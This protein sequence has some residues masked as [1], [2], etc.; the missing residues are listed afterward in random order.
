[1]LKSDA[2]F[3]EYLKFILWEC[4]SFIPIHIKISVEG[5]LILSL[6]MLL[7]SGFGNLVLGVYELCT[8]GVSVTC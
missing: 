8:W 5:S 7:N 4:L 6:S 1:M 3:V 2:W